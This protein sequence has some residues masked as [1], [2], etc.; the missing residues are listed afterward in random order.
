MTEY[1]DTV[2]LGGGM[3]GLMA[4]LLAQRKCPNAKTLVIEA[5]SR[6]GGVMAGGRA[7]GECFDLGT[8]IPQEIGIGAIDELFERALDP[9]SLQRMSSEV[10]DRAGTLV[11]ERMFVDTSYL[12]LLHLNPEIA[13]RVVSHIVGKPQMDRSDPHTPIRLQPAEEVARDWFGDYATRTMILPI[14]RNWF[15]DTDSLSG[16]ALELV[17]LT[18]L[19]VVDELMWLSHA[20]S[21]SFRQRVAFPS[22]LCLPAEYRH[23]RKSI[24]PKYGSSLDFV[25]G[26]ERLCAEQAV[27]ISIRSRV[28]SI[29]LDSRRMKLERNDGQLEVGFRRLIS[30]LGP[31]HTLP[32]VEGS[33]S[34]VIERC[35][36][37]IIHHVAKKP[38]KSELCYI[39]VYSAKSPVFRITNYRAFSGRSDD[40]RFT[41]ELLA[42]E[43]IGDEFAVM[44]ADKV[45]QS[46]G[47]VE[48]GESLQS[49]IELGVAGFPSP[50]IST[51]V[52]FHLAAAQLAP[53]ESDD[54]I[55]T[56]VGAQG[57]AFFQSEI[58]R[59]LHLRLA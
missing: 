24:Y 22:Q 32:L 7:M 4:G 20:S 54:F 49:S 38:I 19:R 26:L 15:G 44:E 31:V 28:K 42:P 57:T 51:F 55:V 23:N 41:S 48:V 33:P 52:Q 3:S 9:S 17:N 46:S 50:K 12:D 14:L 21:S 11:G 8:H 59:H 25:K 16:F 43:T 56:G 39:Y 2:V 47:L 34:L 5:S 10:G 37:K 6:L 13:Q 45:L 29:D 58:L 30:T 35:G 1:F 40:C 53:L 36:S 27:E 18:R